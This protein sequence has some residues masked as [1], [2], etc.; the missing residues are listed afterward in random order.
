MEVL[1]CVIN[2][3]EDMIS[4]VF[5]GVTFLSKLQIAIIFITW[6]PKQQHRTVLEGDQIFSGK[7]WSELRFSDSG[8]GLADETKLSPPLLVLPPYPAILSRLARQ[9]S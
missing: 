4:S 1:L 3:T 8:G 5:V 6:D 7:A 2:G 9:F